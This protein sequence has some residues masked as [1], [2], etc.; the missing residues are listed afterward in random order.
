MRRR[1]SSWRW[2]ACVAAAIAAFGAPARLPAQKPATEGALFL[3][4]PIG[5]RAVG[6]G[7]AIVGDEPGSEAVWWNPAAIARGDRREIAI[8]HSQTII[9]TGDAVTL[10]VPSA[11]LG[12][13]AVGA[14]IVYYGREDITDTVGTVGVLIPQ[15]IVYAATYAT[16][17]ARR[18]A[19]GISYK[20]VQLRLDCS[21]GCAGV[22]TVSASSS[23]LDAGVQARL[24]GLVP[25]TVG[26]AVRNVG[27]RL[28]VNDKDQ[29]DPLPTRV[30]AGVSIDVPNV[31]GIDPQVKIKVSADLL[32]DVHFSAPSP[33]FGASIG[34]RERAFFRS[35]YIFD[36]GDGE[37]DGPS[38]GFGL[39]SGSLVLD[40]GRILRGLSVD[41]GKPPTYVSLRYLF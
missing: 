13:L 1:R 41:A 32:S 40:I 21:G 11:L 30:Q 5:A 7:Q 8:H 3:L 26:V 28:Q 19:A 25:A 12:V 14:N 35:G 9:A 34:Y 10:V 17:I 15:N 33:R 31:Q 29:S 36:R 39:A 16:P 37:G 24:A 20:I 2:S 6:Q 27:P 22:P 4:L 18:F 23:A 38:I